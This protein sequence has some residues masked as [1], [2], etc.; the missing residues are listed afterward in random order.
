[1]NTTK[2]VDNQPNREY[3][4]ALFK[5]ERNVDRTVV[6][7]CRRSTT[8]S[9]HR[10]PPY[11]SPHGSSSPS[12]GGGELLST[13]GLLCL[14]FGR[15]SDDVEATIFSTDSSRE[16]EWKRRWGDTREH[17]I[18]VTHFE[19]LRSI[20]RKCQSRKRRS[21]GVVNSYYWPLPPSYWRDEKLHRSS[22]VNHWCSSR[23]HSENE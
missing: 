8:A 7:D 20:T 21:R 3:R 15:P 14:D 9:S 17:K 6:F 10:R 13:S 23:H 11:F 16:S 18:G 19:S 1:M 12:T 5:G 4:R 2:Y 22:G